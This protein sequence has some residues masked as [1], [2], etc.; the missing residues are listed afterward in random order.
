MMK[1][2]TTSAGAKLAAALLLIICISM[3]V[4]SII[5]T[6]YIYENNLW[7]NEESEYTDT[8]SFKFDLIWKTL[9][10]ADMSINDIMQDPDYE[11]NSSHIYY[12]NEY[13]IDGGYFYLSSSSNYYFA[14]YKNTAA[15][16]AEDG[17]Q[18]PETG[19]PAA[20]PST[21]QLVNPSEISQFERHFYGSDHLNDFNILNMGYGK[22]SNFSKYGSLAFTNDENWD[23]SATTENT[24]VI[25]LSNGF[26]AVATVKEPA[27]YVDQYFLLQTLH[28]IFFPIR[29]WLVF[30]DIILGALN[31]I[32]LLFLLVSAGR[33]PVGKVYDINSI[34]AFDGKNPEHPFSGTSSSADSKGDI[35]AESSSA[36]DPADY[37]DNNTGNTQRPADKD[38]NINNETAQPSADFYENKSNKDS[39]FKNSFSA[40]TGSYY[41]Q[42]IYGKSEPT[43]K[44]RNGLAIKA[45]V[46]EHIPIDLFFI[47]I[48][49]LCSSLITLS[50][51]IISNSLQHT[52]LKF[53]AP[54]M[55][56]SV[57]LF[58]IGIACGIIGL[59]S[60]SVRLKLGKWWRNSV[61]YKF[62][63]WFFRLFGKCFSKLFGA[64]ANKINRILK[65]AAKSAG[66][67]WKLTAIAIFT[68]FI[69]F[70]FGYNIA[71]NSYWGY[72]GIHIPFA[73]MLCLILDMMIIIVILAVSLMMRKLQ[74]GGRA[75]AK[76]EL[77]VKVDTEQMIGDFKEHAENL[78]SIGSGML[79]AIDER[80]RSERLKTE[81]ITNVSHD[82]KTPLTSIVN[83]V[84]LLKKENLSG[85]AGEYVDILDRQSQRLKKLTE[86]LIEASK[87]STGNINV[88][89]NK[90]DICEIV[91]QSVGEYQEKLKAALI[92]TVIDMPENP[93]IAEADGRL[94]WRIMDNLLSNV[95]KYSMPNT[96]VYINVADSENTQ[97]TPN[98]PIAY[99]MVTISI[100]NISRD[101]LNINADELTERFVRGDSSRTTDGSGLG[102]NIARSLAELQGG[103]F[104][105][106]IDGDLFKAEISL[107]K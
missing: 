92:N 45:S 53:A 57:L 20:M 98:Q 37:S 55:V 48:T 1:R 52:A 28:R 10:F 68:I 60:C 4:F 46:I 63:K 26:T 3:F 65:E 41:T 96:R 40:K 17:E 71:Y 95:C 54:M 83:Y 75:L 93:V 77:D 49:G 89:L 32:L 8:R 78:N 5:G 13:Y 90:I 86:D 22:D 102:L 15:S 72:G 43:C 64:P 67:Q 66:I 81:L 16:H 27:E 29:N 84:D 104:N 21:L 19:Q 94:L 101:R 47:I 6:L 74:K 23:T 33:K 79:I 59:M 11:D 25:Q 85:A 38:I 56:L 24:V 62:C 2:L 12:D 88:S 50:A 97:S 100:K 39:L 35:N 51:F 103:K 73:G 105:I 31:L 80:I 61:A 69:N 36:A 70:I 30:I 9:A 107:R 99:G 76:G 44:I 87:A 7:N 82:I 106:S 91:N 34:D 58:D 42:T 14:L 18:I